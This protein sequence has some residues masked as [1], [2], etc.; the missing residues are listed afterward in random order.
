[1]GFL[2]FYGGTK[3]EGD[4]SPH[5]KGGS[6]RKAIVLLALALFL[7]S[8][9][10]TPN[11]QPIDPKVNYSPYATITPIV[12]TMLMFMDKENIK[13]YGVTVV[14]GEEV[15]AWSNQ[16]RQLF[17]TNTLLEKFSYEQLHFIAAHEIAHVKLGHVEKQQLASATIYAGFQVLNIFVPGAGLLNLA[18]N[19]TVT[20]A[21]SRSQEIAADKEA[22]MAICECGFTKDIAVST[23]ERLD[24]L[25]RVKGIDDS[26]RIGI[27]DSHPRIIERI[28]R[29]KN[30]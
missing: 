13:N 9:A 26:N 11:L 12:N 21:Y 2:L 20:R 14:E 6:V 10:T 1:M 15:N 18:V 8:C 27:W 25:A 22:A 23:L 19:P 5:P 3:M 28:E 24:L 30:L 7:F 4:F 17:F 16:D 29:I